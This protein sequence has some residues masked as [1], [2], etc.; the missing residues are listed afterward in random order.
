MQKS[1]QFLSTV[2]Q[3]FIYTQIIDR[4]GDYLARHTRRARAELWKL[5]FRKFR[6]VSIDLK[7]NQRE[8]D[9]SLNQA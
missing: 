3:K 7:V 4:A 6:L 2:Q 8:R 1:L 9:L 5:R